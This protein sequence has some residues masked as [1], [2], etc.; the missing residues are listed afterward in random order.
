MAGNADGLQIGEAL[1][2]V[3]VAC[4]EGG[5]ALL[6]GGSHRILVE[7]LDPC[8]T[9]LDRI[10]RSSVRSLQSDESG[11]DGGAAVCELIEA[12]VQCVED[13]L[14][15]GLHHTASAI[16]TGIVVVRRR[17]RKG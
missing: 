17:R 14:Q 10:G 2:V 15:R 6:N 8:Q 11:V 5:E 13:E 4:F 7:R 16:E 12:G 9:T 1:C 3:G